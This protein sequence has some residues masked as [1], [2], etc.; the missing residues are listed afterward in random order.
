VQVEACSAGP[1]ANASAWRDTPAPPMGRPNMPLF[2]I[3]IYIYTIQYNGIRLEYKICLH[4]VTTKKES[5]KLAIF[6]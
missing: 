5:T 3:Y 6:G 1:S 4:Y 2:G